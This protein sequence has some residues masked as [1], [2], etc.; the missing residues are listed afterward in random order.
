MVSTYGRG[1]WILDDI[2][3]L[4]Q[5]TADARAGAA[6]LFKPRPAYRFR[7]N[8]TP[9]QMT[10]DPTAGQNPPYGAS[11]NY[12]L[13]TAQTDSATIGIADAGGQTVRTFKAPAKAGVNRAWWDLRNEDSKEARLRTP[14]P[15]APDVRLG[16]DGTRAAPAIG[17]MSLLMPPGAY[18]VKVRVAGQEL[19]QP[20]VVRK[21]PNSG[22]SEEEIQTQAKLLADLQGDLNAVVDIV[23][24]MESVRGQLVGLRS[25]LPAELRVA[26]DS[27]EHRFSALEGELHDLRITGR[28]QDNIRWPTRL[29]GQITYL[30]Q[31]V[32]SSDFAP[33][34]QQGDVRD[35]LAG[36]LKT[37]RSRFD[38]MVNQDL[39][40]FN[41]RLKERSVG[42]VVA[43]VESK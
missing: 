31:G 22:G 11:I 28:G 10:D 8:T 18:T 35:L 19:T 12:W 39:A 42:V 33:T 2:T 29:A 34:A 40:Q 5:L 4:E 32:A 7:L 3:P 36:Q 37:V 1:F 20:L 24:Q 17:R 21:D 26:A 16:P 14:V 43:G 27:L 30:A 41:S 25:V 9:N 6:Y 38:T 13:K 23:N 15:Y